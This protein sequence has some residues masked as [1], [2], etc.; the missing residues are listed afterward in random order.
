MKQN[1]STLYLVVNDK[2]P[3]HFSSATAPTNMPCVSPEIFQ[4]RIRLSNCVFMEVD[5]SLRLMAMLCRF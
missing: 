2:E 3:G 4:G 5:L 1:V